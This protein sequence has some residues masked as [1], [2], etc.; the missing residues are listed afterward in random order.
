MAIFGQNASYIGGILRWLT[1]DATAARYPVGDRACSVGTGGATPK[2]ALV[3]DGL[4]SSLLFW[5][6]AAKA[7]LASSTDETTIIGGRLGPIYPGA[8]TQG[9]IPAGYLNRV[10]AGI[11]IVTTGV[12]ST[13]GTPNLTIKALLG[14]SVIYTSGAK[15]LVSTPAL[16]P[17]KF[18][19]NGFVVTTGGTGTILGQGHFIYTPAGVTASCISA[20]MAA[21]TTDLTVAL[22]PD[23]TATWGASDAANL[24]GGHLTLV[25]YW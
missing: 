11:R 6:S 12:L 24:I 4:P 22:I 17:F 5:T 16:M 3:N 10:G 8:P 20:T 21:I 1:D 25:S 7:D 15:A 14:V 2:R 19:Y 18:E 9:T 23:V 13:N